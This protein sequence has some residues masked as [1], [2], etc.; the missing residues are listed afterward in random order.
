M[1]PVQHRWNAEDYA[2]NSSAQLQWA[3]ELIAKLALRGSE[4]VLDIGCGD[5]KITGRLALAAKKGN[6]LG[7]DQSQDMIRLASE[8]FPAEK[9]PNLSFLR[10]DATEIRLSKKFDIAFSNATLHWVKNH[11]AVLRGVRACLN[12][13]GKILFQMGGSGNAAE[14]FVAIEEVLR[15]ERW[16]GC[17][18]DFPSPYHF[19]APE[20]YEAWLLQ[21]GFLPVR[22]ELVPKDM[23]HQGTE[24]FKGWL[25]TTWFPYTDHLPI[26]LRDAFLS[27]LVETYVTAH[28][29]DALGNIHVKMVRLEVE[30]HTL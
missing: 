29:A 9:Y 5:G 14:V 8:Q 25:R 11:I 2:K 4:S 6:V 3:Q 26:E 23:Q 28:P 1:Q 18:G 13:G 15:R 27:E 19:Y 30:A 17:Y 12:S 21:S 22:L 24:G 20:E 10:M 7:I 16:Q